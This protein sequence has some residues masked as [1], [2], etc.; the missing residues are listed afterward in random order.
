MPRDH[1][2]TTRIQQ[3]ARLVAQTYYGDEG[4]WLCD[5]F[6]AINHAYFDGELP[7][8]HISIELT[9]H[10]GCLAWCASHDSRPPRIA[11][12][13]TLFGFR[14]I[15]NPWGLPTEWLGKAMAFD[16]LL[17]ECL[18][19]SVYYRLGGAVGPT[20]HNNVQWVSEVN[21]I[22]PYLGFA[23]IKAGRQIASR[24]PIEGETTKTG[25]PK[26]KVQKVT[27]GNISFRAVAGFPH[28]LRCERKEAAQYYVADKV[29]LVF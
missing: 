21:R 19:V 9:A 29:P 3:A 6:E 11:I 8:P 15:E 4:R 1:H 17:H 16:A 25:K 22:A 23:D 18:H 14:E 26:T 27:N 7:Y 5:A 28:V 24:V 20:S 2:S 13:P 10:G 12:H